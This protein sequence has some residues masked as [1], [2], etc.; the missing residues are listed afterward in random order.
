MQKNVRTLFCL[1]LLLSVLLPHA[2]LAAVVDR[3]VAIV[4]NDTITLSEINELAKPYFD[5]VRAQAPP[6]QQAEGMAQA[7]HHVFHQ[8]AFGAVLHE[9]QRR[10]RTQARHFPLRR[11]VERARGARREGGRQNGH[12]NS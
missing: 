2:S 4:N 10:A 5:Q 3:N 12:E 8:G 6:D 1:V 9:Q 7:A 11:L